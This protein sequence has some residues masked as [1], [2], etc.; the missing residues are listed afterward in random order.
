MVA[1]YYCLRDSTPALSRDVLTT[2]RLPTSWDT[3]T[4][5][6]SSVLH[7]YRTLLQS[8]LVGKNKL[9]FSLLVMSQ[10]YAQF[11][12]ACSVVLHVTERWVGV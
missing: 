11:S 3:L 12:V 2:L 5:A 6:A 1:V 7:N 10:V 9:L 4:Y 8:R